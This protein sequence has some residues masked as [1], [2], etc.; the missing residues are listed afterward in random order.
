MTNLAAEALARWVASDASLS[1]VSGR[2]NLVYR[3]AT[4]DGDF[5]LRIRRSGLRSRA[6]LVSELAWL[7]AMDRAGLSVPRPVPSLSGSLLET[8]GGREADMTVWLK[9]SPL[10]RSGEPLRLGDAPQ[11]F[12]RLGREIALLHDACDEFRPPEGFVRRRWDLDGLLG[13]EPLWGRFW[14]NPT[15][16]KETRG[17]LERFR[18]EASRQ[19]E[20]RAG[21][22]DHGLIHADLVRE[23]V[24]LD[25]GHDRLRLL[26]FDDGGFGFRPFDIAGALLKN[27]KEPG[28]P[29]LESSLVEGYRT[30]RRLDVSL[31]GLFMAL[32]AVTYV[33]WIVPRMSEDGS[34][35]RNA[36][37]ID[38]ACDLCAAYFGEPRP[39]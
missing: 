35:E 37:F 16:D 1:F 9:G 38:D 8:V 28:Y 11:E 13:E 39:A 10:G 24:L 2:E 32:R 27:R 19:L 7:D 6:E 5:A 14:E 30:A 17:L 31:L 4:R 20:L 34:R 25:D 15:L 21:D 29:E 3:V 12:F 33:G 22:L 36:R 23:N 26:D 18:R